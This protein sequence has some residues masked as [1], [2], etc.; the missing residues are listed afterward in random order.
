MRD[1]SAELAAQKER[2]EKESNT[3]DT[4]NKHY[5][6]TPE[7]GKI[8]RHFTESSYPLNNSLWKK[9][10]ENSQRINEMKGLINKHRTP[11]DMTVYSKS[12]HDPNKLKDENGVVHH[13]AFLSSSVHH[14][15]VRHY[16]ERNSL[17]TKLTP[18][19]EKVNHMWH[20]H[21][22]KGSPGAF[23]H[24][25]HS[26]NPKYKEFVMQGG[27]NLQHHHT[28]IEQGTEKG[29]SWLHHHLTLMK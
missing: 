14:S 16:F 21:V 15:T 3:L 27:S 23:I 10:N 1:F 19:I 13:P 25:E 29:E 18:T 6:W 2:R 4:L 7:E 28:E 20:I 22:P 11:E 5:H 8:L 9:D 26:L 12:V 24:D 17:Y